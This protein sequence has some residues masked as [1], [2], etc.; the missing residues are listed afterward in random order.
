M[1]NKEECELV[2]FRKIVFVLFVVVFGFDVIYAQNPQN[3]IED[4]IDENY[5]NKALST[6]IYG[7]N[8]D[9]SDAPKTQRVLIPIKNTINVLH[10]AIIDAKRYEDARERLIDFNGEILRGGIYEQNLYMSANRKISY[11]LNDKVLEVNA[12]CEK[13][14][15]TINN[16]SNG[17]F[18]LHLSNNPT[19][20]VAIVLNVNKSMQK[21]ISALKDIAPYLAKHILGEDFNKEDS[22]YA[23]I[24]LTTFSYIMIYDLGTFYDSQSFANALNQIKGRDSNDAI[25]NNA[26][27][28]AMRNF[29]KD[30]SL[31]KEVYLIT[32]G[33]PSDMKNMQKM[34]TI[35]QNLNA[36]ITKNTKS[37]FDNR[38]KIHTFALSE[39]LDVLKQ[40][41]DST[42]G[43]YNKANNV[44]D[45]KKQILTV[46]N[47][48]KPFDMNELNNEIR[49]SKSNKIY[50]PNKPK[51]K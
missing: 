20:E 26:I 1:S 12:V 51:N 10:N 2:D 8:C 22:R 49:P 19:K 24:S 16:F 34:L 47:D 32:N 44:Y 42:G 11:S 41:A 18:G 7:E 14:S 6:L 9:K 4:T 50:D 45:F 30:N 43:T 29:T 15:F 23:K 38:V 28:E 13:Q 37:K 35:T 25:F 27:I 5:V 39:N 40:L 46:S 36:N 21:Y 17:D 3:S 48:G 33:K 31:K